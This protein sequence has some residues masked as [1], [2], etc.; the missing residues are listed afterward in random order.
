[1]S[2]E[3]PLRFAT[4]AVH[5]STHL[6]KTETMGPIRSISTPIYLS[7]TFAFR[8][9]DHGARIFA[10]EEAGYFYTRLGNPTTAALEREMAFLE[11]GEAALACASGMGATALACLTLC[12]TGDNIVSSDTLYGGTHQLFTQTLPVALYTGLV[13]VP[14]I[15]LADFFG[16]LGRED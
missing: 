11:D 12:G 14:I 6:D 8:D 2:S 13:G 7:S 1:M 9:A 15:R 10:G 4:L 3:K 5:G 16:L